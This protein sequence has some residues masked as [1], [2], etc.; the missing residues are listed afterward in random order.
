MN[1]SR[2]MIFSAHLNSNKL[3]IFHWSLVLAVEIDE[4]RFSTFLVIQQQLTFNILDRLLYSGIMGRSRS[5][6]GLA[7]SY[8]VGSYLAGVFIDFLDIHIEVRDILQLIML[9][10]LYEVHPFWA[11]SI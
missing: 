10:Q 11:A 1:I 7:L 6:L 3:P 2:Y 5:K 8:H 9:E 4:I